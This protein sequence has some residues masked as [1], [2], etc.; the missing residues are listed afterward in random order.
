MCPSLHIKI[1]QNSRLDVHPLNFIENIKMVLTHPH[2]GAKQPS[3]H[4][5]TKH[6]L[7]LRIGTWPE[8]PDDECN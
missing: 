7:L 6:H 8:Q 2:C 1:N 4:Q 5:D 3:F